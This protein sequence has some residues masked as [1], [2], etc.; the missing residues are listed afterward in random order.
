MY[1]ICT[2]IPSPGAACADGFDKKEADVV[3]RQL[4]KGAGM[5]IEGVA[6]PDGDVDILQ[7]VIQ[8]DGDESDLSDCTFTDW[9][10]DEPCATAIGVICNWE[11]EFS[12]EE[13]GALHIVKRN[14]LG[15]MSGRLEVCHYKQWGKIFILLHTCFSNH[16]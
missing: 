10:A 12:C 11:E 7:K 13:E 16:L 2:V 4:G 9:E 1:C 8:C 3:C 15:P 6:A 5:F 14:V